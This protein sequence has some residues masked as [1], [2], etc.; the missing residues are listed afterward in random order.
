ME[1]YGE[2]CVVVYPVRSYDFFCIKIP[3]KL[4]RF[5][6]NYWLIGV[7]P[8]EMLGRLDKEMNEGNQG[9]LEKMSASSMSF[10]PIRK[11]PMIQERI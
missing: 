3:Q 10:L 9:K 1:K 5:T 11:P 7:G 4:N 2:V 6:K 8:I